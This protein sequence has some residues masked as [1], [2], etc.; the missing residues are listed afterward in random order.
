MSSTETGEQKAVRAAFTAWSVAEVRGAYERAVTKYA[1][2]GP[3]N[4]ED[5]DDGGGGGGEGEDGEEEIEEI[6]ISRC[7]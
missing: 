7:V 4:E 1:E 5:D 2:A 6:M 3:S